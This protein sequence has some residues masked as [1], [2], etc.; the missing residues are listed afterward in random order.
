M[1]INS[2]FPQ[3]TTVFDSSSDHPTNLLCSGLIKNALRRILPSSFFSS[4]EEKENKESDFR[5]FTKDLPIVKWL[6][7]GVLPNKNLSIFLLCRYRANASK[8]F[9]DIVSRWLIPGK[10]L[11]IGLFFSTDFKLSEKEKEVYTISELV[12]CLDDSIDLEIIRHHLPIIESEIRLGVTSVYHASRIMEIKGLASDEKTSLIQEKIAFLIQKRPKDFDYDIFS[13]MQHFFVMCREEFKSVR[14]YSHMSRIISVFYLFRKVLRQHVEA[15]PRKRHLSLKLMKTR[16][17]FPLKTKK[18]LAIFVGLNFL[19]ENEMFEE[20]HIVKALQNYIPELKAIE[21][22]FFI[23]EN[24]ED[25]IQIIYLEVEKENGEDFSL[26]EVK[27]LRRVLPEDLKNRVEQLMRPIFMPRNEEEVMRHIVTLSQQLKYIRDL[28]QVVISFDEQTDLD[29]CFTVVLVRI[30]IPGSLSLKQLFERAKVNLT[31]TADR[32]KRVGMLRNRYPK[33]ATVFRLRLSNIPFLREDHSVDLYKARQEIICQLQKAVGE[34][35]DFNGGMIAKQLEVFLSLKKTLG[36]IGR[37]HE[38][39][40]ENFFHSLFPVE[41]RSVVD[42][43]PLKDLFL[44][45]LS[46]THEDKYRRKN[47]PFIKETET[48]LYVLIPVREILIKQK[49]FEAIDQLQLISSQMVCLHLHLSEILYL[50]YI[51]FDDTQE[52][53]ELFL[54]GIK[55][56]F[57][58]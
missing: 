7:W 35:R 15:F 49:I 41:L 14:E 26:E 56:N 3:L 29:L 46:L 40:L 28:P 12:L 24:R 5:T 52:K 54:K 11:N 47:I 2:S 16:L 34:V 55:Q 1:N 25:S 18:V 13:Q 51:Y 22:S 31:F 9:Y 42:P 43:I 21:D 37:Q 38:F 45:L 57:Y 48:A 23:D 32:V 44:M 39:L 4:L 53:R 30:L 20:R 17:Q 27:K 8:F 6:E 50:G 58:L 19:K 10:R 33:E 36:E